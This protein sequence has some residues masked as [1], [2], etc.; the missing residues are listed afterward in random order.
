MNQALFL[1]LVSSICPGLKWMSF[2][3]ANM[4]LDEVIELGTK[5]SELKAHY[6]TLTGGIEGHSF[7]LTVTGP[8][9]P[10]SLAARIA[11]LATSITSGTYVEIQLLE[12]ISMAQWVEVQKQVARYHWPIGIDYCLSNNIIFVERPDSSGNIYP[13]NQQYF[14]KPIAT[15]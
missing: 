6:P 5:L 15:N 4:T 10:A 13:F 7:T 2:L 3:P 11:L 12:S 8:L 9:D 14:P 1:N